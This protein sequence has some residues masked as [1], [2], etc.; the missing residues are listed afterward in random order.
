MTFIRVQLPSPF[1]ISATLGRRWCSLRPSGTSIRH[2]GDIDDA[3]VSS[4]DLL[5]DAVEDV[6]EQG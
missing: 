2:S 4:S 3:L 1:A 6:L 5:A